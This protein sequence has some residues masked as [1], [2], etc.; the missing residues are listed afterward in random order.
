[1]GHHA[2]GCERGVVLFT[3]FFH[4]LLISENRLQPWRAHMHE[5]KKN[6]VITMLEHDG[7]YRSVIMDAT[8]V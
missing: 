2:T 7:N 8:S 3:C 6:I 1:M 5:K 4:F